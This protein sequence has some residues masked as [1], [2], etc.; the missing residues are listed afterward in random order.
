MQP[1]PGV[2]PQPTGRPRRNTQHLCGVF[3]RHAGKIP[4]VHQLHGLRMNRLQAVQGGIQGQQ[5]LVKLRDFDRDVRQ[6]RTDQLPPR[7]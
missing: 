1:G 7:A 6:F 4:Q 2:C 3:P 5:I